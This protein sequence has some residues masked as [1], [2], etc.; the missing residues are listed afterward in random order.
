MKRSFFKTP[1]LEEVREKQA[2]KRELMKMKPQ[3][4]LGRKKVRKAIRIGE[5]TKN[6]ISP[7]RLKPSNKK[8]TLP[9]FL[10]AIPESQAH[11]SGTFQKRLWKIT[12]DYV[13]I[14]D[15]YAYGVCVATGKRFERWQDSHAGHLKPY[16]R[17]NALF[18][19]DTR[20]I[21]AQHGNSNKWGN[22]D[23][24]KDFEKVVR[25]RGYDFDT[26]LEE[27]RQAEGASLRDSE[28]LEEIKKRLLL[29][30]ELPEKP[31]YFER[32]YSL[33]NTL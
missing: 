21:H 28:V 26:F 20:N 17:C 24:F 4:A 6:K 22:Y 32:A 2:E 30:K 5:A 10:K 16:S 23:T 8:K 12:S 31:D 3:N 33:L 29:M 1:T 18:K 27:N 15:F 25:N 13:R 9:S 11:G 7:Y 14:R 19:F